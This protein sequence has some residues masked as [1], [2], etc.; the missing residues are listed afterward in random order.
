MSLLRH[1][2]GDATRRDCKKRALG[3]RFPSTKLDP[4]GPGGLLDATPQPGI[5]RDQDGVPHLRERDV[6]AVVER[7]VRREGDVRGAG[8][9]AIERDEPPAGPY[10]GTARA[11][12]PNRSRL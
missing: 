6:D 2:R 7:A 4:V 3:Y 10:G 8:Q 1:S 11:S 5:R 9:E 12:S